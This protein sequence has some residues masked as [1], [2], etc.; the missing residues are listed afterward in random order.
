[1][2]RDRDPYER[3]LD[4]LRRRLRAG[5]FGHGQPLQIL[6]LAKATGV[7]STPVREAL[8]R[9]AGEGLVERAASGYVTPRPD[10]A[11]VGDL[12]R[13]DEVYALA[14]IARP[15]DHGEADARA[16]PDPAGGADAVSSVERIET[17]LAR[18]GS[19]GNPALLAARRNLWNRLAPFRLAEAAVF[20]D[21]EAE[22]TEL[23]AGFADGPG[24][25]HRRLIRRYYRR[26][27]RAATAILAASLD[28]ERRSNIP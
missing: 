2:G 19:S 23:A 5:A 4:L 9:L 10:A 21:L 17:L 16:P 7:S 28:S 18:L 6:K 11:G 1:M 3:A 20:D 15:A 24:G 22:L 27:T 13:L 26:R 8:A 12:Y 25:E 14:G